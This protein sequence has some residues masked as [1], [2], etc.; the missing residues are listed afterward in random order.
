MDGG[1][2]SPTYGKGVPR[3]KRTLGRRLILWTGIIGTVRMRHGRTTNHNQ[4]EMVIR[5]LDPEPIRK[6]L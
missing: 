1:T 4:F 3:T 2:S 5:M 6:N